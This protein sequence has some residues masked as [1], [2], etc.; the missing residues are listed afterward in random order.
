LEKIPAC[1]PKTAGKAII[2]AFF[3]AFFVKF[4]ILDFM[5]AEG[6]SMAPAIKPG[7]VLL[8]C[9]VFYG[10]RL[11]WSGMYV[12]QWRGVRE[13]DVL[14]FYTPHGDIAVKR[15]VEILPD[16]RFIALGDNNTQ[17]YDSR[18]YGPIP[19]NKIIGRVLG[20]K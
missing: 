9:R 14:V 10:L 11:P 19:K 2:G 4:F 6:Q 8:V 18:N 1:S 20:I 7:T 12:F 3:V 17:S 15:C 13:G 16:G 5:V